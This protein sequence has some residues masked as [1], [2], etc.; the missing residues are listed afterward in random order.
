MAS[1]EGSYVLSLCTLEPRKNIEQVLRCF[2][3]LVREN[4]LPELSLVLAGTKG[5]DF[6]RIFDEIKGAAEIRGRIIVTG[7]VDDDDLPA[8][9][10]GATMFVYP[11]FYEGFG[12]P[13]LE[14]M[15]C[16]VPV[17]SSN[18]SSLPE[19]VG[20]AGLMVDPADEAGLCQAMYRLCHEQSLREQLSARAVARARLFSW[21]RC[22]RETV[23][24][25]EPHWRVDALAA[26]WQVGL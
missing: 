2:V 17:I 15:Q 5:W 6:E 18:T 16:G 26:S 12:L 8:L 19:V 10:G 14:A 23:A 13:P 25:T 1:P 20:D 7:Y 11:S 24:A 4:P 22:G 9:Y 3:R 21:E